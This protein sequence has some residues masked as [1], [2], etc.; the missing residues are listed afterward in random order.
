MATFRQRDGGR[1]QAI[2]RRTDLKASRSFDKKADAVAWARAQERDADLAGTMPTK[3]A[4]TL[5]AVVDRYELE[6]WPEKRWG[7]SKANELDVLRRDLGARL[8]AD[9]TQ[10]VILAYVRGLKITPGGVTTRLSYLREALRTARDLW[11]VRVPLAEL[12]G[13]ISSAKRMKLAGKSNVR[14]RRPTQA[15][16][17]AVIAYAEGQTRSVIDLG[18]I[19]RVLAILPL[20][21]GELLGIEWGDLDTKRRSALIRSR[22]HPDARV[23]E[24]NDQ[25]VPLISFKGV[26][27]FAL[28]ADRP[29]YMPSPFPYKRVSVTAAFSMAALRCQI[30][31]LHLHDLRAHAL[32]SLLEAGVPIPQVALISGHRNWKTL[33]RHYARIDPMAVH[34]AV[35]R[36]E[37]TGVPNTR[38][39]TSPK[40]GGAGRIS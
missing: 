17:D 35:T 4:G 19:V 23:R 28:I 13:A 40:K 30:K 2:I 9:L 7:S 11:G 18:A 39:L 27:T 32:S 33:A 6:I 15:E 26:D 29:R 5:K 1:W 31:D 8:L 14:T 21:A 34:D 22:K 36:A 16:L 24:K 10:P 25:E 3:M 37:T 12:D 38:A 20:R